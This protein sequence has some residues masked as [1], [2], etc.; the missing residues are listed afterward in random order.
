MI[1]ETDG[2][3]NMT[4]G[5]SVKISIKHIKLLLVQSSVTQRRNKYIKELGNI[6]IVMEAIKDKLKLKIKQL[7]NDE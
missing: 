3:I 1:Q 7:E 4:R 2:K 5:S 6:N